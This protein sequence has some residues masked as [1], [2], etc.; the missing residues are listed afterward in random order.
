MRLLTP[1]LVQKE[2]IP[3]CQ[4]DKQEKLSSPLEQ[5]DREDKIFRAMVM[6]NTYKKKALIT[7]EAQDGVKQVKTTVWAM[8]NENVILKNGITIPQCNI[9]NIEV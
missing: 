4:F 6:G 8:T 7:F 3:L 9:L 2:V 1:E 5:K